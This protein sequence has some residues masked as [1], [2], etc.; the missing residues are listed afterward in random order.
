MLISEEDLKNLTFRYPQTITELGLRM[1]ESNQNKLTFKESIAQ[2]KQ[3][4]N[5]EGGLISEEKIT[6]KSQESK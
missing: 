1:T 5:L 4:H 3:P 2:S 6:L